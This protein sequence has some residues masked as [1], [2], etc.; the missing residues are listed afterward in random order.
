MDPHASH[1]EIG[2]KRALYERDLQAAGHHLG[3]RDLPVA[4]L[5]AVAA[6]SAEAEAIARQG[7]QWTV[8][9]YAG[10]PRGDVASTGIDRS[11]EED[12]VERYVKDV[13]LWGSP[14][15]VVDKIAELQE[16]GLNYL[17]CAPLSH[18]SFTLFTD[19]VLPVIS[20]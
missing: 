2:R 1:A 10:K 3:G 9:S 7:A 17:L 12:P 8:A 5:L 15:E 13:I 18:E 11:E 19:K 6:T 16:Q 4:R 14:A 20:A